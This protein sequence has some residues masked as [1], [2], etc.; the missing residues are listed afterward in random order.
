MCVVSAVLLVI[1]TVT[2]S[3]QSGLPLELHG[4][5]RTNHPLYGMAR[6]LELSFPT[7]GP[8][9]LI[10]IESS[11]TPD[12]RAVWTPRAVV[13]SAVAAS[14]VPF[15][16]HEIAPHDTPD[17]LFIRARLDDT[18][19][20]RHP[21]PGR[22]PAYIE[23][24]AYHV[25]EETGFSLEELRNRVAES[26][27]L[28]MS[29]NLVLV[30]SAAHG[31]IPHTF[32]AMHFW[33][34]V[35]DLTLIRDG[36]PGLYE[37]IVDQL[38][39]GDPEAASVKAAWRA[40]TGLGR[41]LF[42]VRDFVSE[43][44]LGFVEWN[45]VPFAMAIDLDA[46]EVQE[47]QIH[48]LQ[49]QGLGRLH[50][51]RVDELRAAMSDF[52]NRSDGELWSLCLRGNL[53]RSFHQAVIVDRIT[54][55]SGPMLHIVRRNLTCT[56][57]RLGPPPTDEPPEEP[58]PPIKPPPGGGGDGS[59]ERKK[60]W[61]MARLPPVQEGGGPGRAPEVEEQPPVGSKPAEESGPQQFPGLRNEQQKIQDLLRQADEAVQRMREDYQADREL[62]RNMSYEWIPGVQ[63]KNP[64][65]QQIYDRYATRVAA[66][67]AEIAELEREAGACLAKVRD[68]IRSASPEIRALLSRN[69]IWNNVVD[70]FGKWSNLQQDCPFP[71]FPG[72]GP[73]GGFEVIGAKMDRFARSIIRAMQQGSSW[74]KAVEDALAC[75]LNS[76]YGA[77]N[78]NSFMHEAMRQF[79]DCLRKLYERKFRF[80]LALFY[81]ELTE[82]ERE[83]M[84]PVLFEGE[85]GFTPALE[86]ELSRLRAAIEANDAKVNGLVAGVA[87]RADTI[88]NVLLREFHAAV[89]ECLNAALAQIRIMQNIARILRAALV[90]AVTPGAPGSTPSY[91]IPAP[92]QGGE[93]AGRAA[94]CQAVTQLLSH[95]AVQNCPGLKA[96]LMSLQAGECR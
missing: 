8:S 68:G 58:E 63:F 38:L 80:A 85:G 13:P 32:T 15:L 54:S 73:G 75:P 18:A 19:E 77:V 20:V 41:R 44:R 42:V 23:G 1:G 87:T 28:A 3:A 55:L 83:R 2:V 6:A 34:H 33:P 88:S 29:N 57:G 12:D 24:V 96:Y 9:G 94:F 37:T 43:V 70:G 53:R 16:L 76:P 36:D 56:Q 4:I 91:P 10:G 5:T 61:S 48:G 89:R 27:G 66:I 78:P 86:E 45:E 11:S 82:E 81:P 25:D 79:A 52:R 92:S 59:G 35:L 64:C 40:A 46:L 90:E 51:P 93:A 69:G 74:D 71:T 17:V 62:L 49:S 21:F 60:D 47:L 30:S 39:A 84:I 65:I 14:A 72:A 50:D 95:P 7:A 26:P 22:L 31:S 67:Q